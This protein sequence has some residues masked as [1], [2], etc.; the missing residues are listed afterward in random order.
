MNYCFRYLL[1]ALLLLAACGSGEEAVLEVPTP[2]VGAT[3]AS[4]AVPPTPNTPLPTANTPL[5]TPTLVPTPTLMPTE[6]AVAPPQ[7]SPP[8]QPL[9]QL[10]ML[11]HTAVFIADGALKMWGQ[12]TQELK[13]LLPGGPANATRTSPTDAITGDISRFVVSDEAKQLLALKVTDRT[14]SDGG[15]LYQYDLIWVDIGSGSSQ[16]VA[17]GLRG[18]VD[19]ALSNDGRH[20]IYLAQRPGSPNSEQYTITLLETAAGSLPRA[21]TDCQL[22]CGSFAWHPDNQNVAWTDQQGLWLLN[23]SG[24]PTR[25]VANAF[26]VEP[27]NVLIHAPISWARNGRFLLIW[28]GRYEGGN[29]AILDVTNSRV[30]ELPDSFVYASPAIVE[31]TW[32]DDSRLL[33]TRPDSSNPLEGSPTL[34]IWRI[35]D[36][37][38]DLTREATQTLTTLHGFPLAPKHLPDG[39]FGFALSRPSDGQTSG[40]Y[41]LKGINDTLTRLTGIPPANATYETSVQWLPDG[42][43]ALIANQSGQVTLALA[44]ADTLFDLTPLL[45]QSPHSFH[46]L[47]RFG[48]NSP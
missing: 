15:V 20:A 3:L 28:Q 35:P 23:L 4:T 11:G 32:M 22:P 21:L 12:G 45:G 47:P 8:L 19:F 44:A 2:V 39:R 38:S 42:T 26:G 14:D 16:T 17:T 31:A 7:T 13:T 43:G 1:L 27:A 41:A 34:E 46:W 33:V 25:L 18:N 24:Q 9:T 37:G 10:P 40:L 29:R 36:S 6:T 48:L 30:L 5:S